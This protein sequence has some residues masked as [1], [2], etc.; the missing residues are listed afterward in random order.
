MRRALPFLA[1]AFALLVPATAGANAPPSCQSFL[2]VNDEEVITPLAEHAVIDEPCGAGDYSL[3]VSQQPAHG[4]VDVSGTTLTYVHTSTIPGTDRF[5]YT[6]TDND[7]GE[8]SAP[9]EIDLII[10]SPPACPS[11][12]LSVLAGRRLELPASPC[13][14]PDGD[15]YTVEV[16][17]LPQH[18]MLDFGPA[19][20]PDPGF[21]GT[22]TFV[23]WAY[24]D[25]LVSDPATVTIAVTNPVLGPPPPPPLKDT[26]APVASL[27]S[28]PGQK[29]KQVLAKGLHLTLASNEAGKATVTVSVDAKT[30]RKLHIKREVGRASAAVRAGKLELTVKLGAKARKAFKKLR[31]VRLSVKAVVTDA[32]GN[33]ATRSLTVTLKR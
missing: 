9:A 2:S 20:T 8:P 16:L 33:P 13:Q 28:A 22:D 11:A 6:A 27:A 21:V 23:Y 4:R 25:F 17:Q 24:D 26:T 1:A 5:T 31:K 19:Y 29:L 3:D 7:T 10:D 12:S 15:D 18:G 30:A 14:D 32:A